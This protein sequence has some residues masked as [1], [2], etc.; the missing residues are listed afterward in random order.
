MTT[1]IASVPGDAPI[2]LWDNSNHLLAFESGN[3]SAP[4][5]S[6]GYL[7]V[8]I[9]KEAGVTNAPGSPLQFESPISVVVDGP[10]M[11][12]QSLTAQAQL[13]AVK[14]DMC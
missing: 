9:V 6:N 3:S 5:A 1:Q 8:W 12:V 11:A 7:Y 2:L 10:G 14:W 13:Q 4:S